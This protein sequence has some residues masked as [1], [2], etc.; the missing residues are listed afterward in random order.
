MY[1]LYVEA[2]NIPVLTVFILKNDCEA[3]LPFQFIPFN[4]LQYCSTFSGLD[5]SSHNKFDD[6]FKS[7]QSPSWSG[8]NPVLN[9]VTHFQGNY[10]KKTVLSMPGDDVIRIS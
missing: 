4:L 5:V 6:H 10:H 9:I 1:L 3:R 7:E 2:V 8:E